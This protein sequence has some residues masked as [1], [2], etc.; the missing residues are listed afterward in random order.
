MFVLSRNLVN[1]SYVLSD[2]RH[3]EYFRIMPLDYS[4]HGV[5]F[6]HFVKESG[7]KLQMSGGNF[8]AKKD[9]WQSIV[10]TWDRGASVG[11]LYLNG[12]LVNRSA[13]KELPWMRSYNAHRQLNLCWK[14][15]NPFN[16]LA[17]EDSG[18]F[19]GW[20]SSLELY[21]YPFTQDNVTQ[22]HNRGKIQGDPKKCHPQN[23]LYNPQKSRHQFHLWFAK[24]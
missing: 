24:F 20:M 5:M 1:Y 10:V 17:Y 16:K 7:L 11:R 3:P 18:W 2:W 6:A 13:G 8:S 21:F 12:N 4:H 15:D 22:F 14:G 19:Y 23:C 9:Q